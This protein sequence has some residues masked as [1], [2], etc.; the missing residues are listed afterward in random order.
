MARIARVPYD[1][2]DEIFSIE[3]EYLRAKRPCG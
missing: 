1:E 2:P 3:L